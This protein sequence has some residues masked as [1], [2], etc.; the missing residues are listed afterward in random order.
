[1]YRTVRAIIDERREVH[2]AE[3]VVLPASRRALLVIL[4][5]GDEA[6]PGEAAL[7]SESSLAADWNR[8]EEDRAWQS[9]Q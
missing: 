1:M 8:V 6:G 5:E 7:L 3:D 2:V 4:D 9:L